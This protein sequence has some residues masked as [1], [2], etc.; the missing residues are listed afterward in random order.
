MDLTYWHCRAALAYI[1][2]A[3][4]GSMQVWKDQCILMQK[5]IAK[6]FPHTGVS[7][8]IFPSANHQENVVGEFPWCQ[9]SVELVFA[10]IKLEH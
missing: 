6:W 3:S 1:K 7:Q 8:T 9:V 2:R 10:T 4:Q 5:E